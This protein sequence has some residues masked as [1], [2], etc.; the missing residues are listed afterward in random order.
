MGCASALALAAGCQRLGRGGGNVDAVVNL[1]GSG[2]V[3][4]E[5]LWAALDC[6]T[7]YACSCDRTPAAST[8]RRSS[9]QSGKPRAFDAIVRGK[10]ASD[11]VD[12][13]ALFGRNSQTL[14]LQMNGH[15][16]PEFVAVEGLLA[17]KLRGS[18][19]SQGRRRVPP[20]IGAAMSAS[21]QTRRFRDVRLTSGLPPTAD[22]FRVDQHFAFGPRP[23]ILSD[24]GPE[25]LGR[26]VQGCIAIEGNLI[27]LLA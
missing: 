26:R 6:P 17:T 2:N 5:F 1:G 14:P 22:I 13:L 8:K 20:M 12:K 16:R 23:V 10:Y 24:A 4:P 11:C 25:H 7:G 19:G 21:G 18:D 9:G 3:A 15:C 27:V